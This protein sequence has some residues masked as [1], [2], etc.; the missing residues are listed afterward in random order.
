MTFVRFCRVVVAALVAAAC[1]R[2]ASAGEL[3]AELQG[4]WKLVSVEREGEPAGSSERQP[5]LV[6]K[7]DTATHDGEKF[8]TMTADATAAPKL[9]DLRCADPDRTYEAIY[10]IEGDMLKICVNTQTEGAKERPAAFSIQGHESWRLL[11]F[12]R[13]KA[14]SPDSASAYVGLQLRINE[15][16][17]EISV[18]STLKNGPAEKAGLQRGDLILKIGDT[19]FSKLKPAV[20]AVRQAKPGDELSFHIRRDGKEREIRIKAAVLPF[21]WVA[22]LN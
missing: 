5:R 7:G 15:E 13:D 16:R 9:I 21:A 6:I 12:E 20:E 18:E 22:Q 17:N 3:P 2:G 1:S 14:D 10:S 8:A 4:T 19:A 11:V